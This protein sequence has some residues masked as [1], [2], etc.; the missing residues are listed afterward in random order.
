ME[1]NISHKGIV[2][3]V[4]E[5]NT[6]VEILSTSACASCHAAGLCTASEAAKK[7]VVVV[8]DPSDPHFVGEEVDVVLAESLGLKAV[9]ISYV[10]P[11]FILLI[12]VVSLS[13]M[14]ISEIVAGLAG[15]AA[16]GIY[17]LILY[18]RRDSISREYS[19]RIGK[20]AVVD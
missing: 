11:L 8:T 16:A 6:V 10:V 15:I 20:K 14:Q 3:S 19:F 4:D 9:L 13:Y 18:F 2:K 1:N 17:Y 7:E 5:R 12:L